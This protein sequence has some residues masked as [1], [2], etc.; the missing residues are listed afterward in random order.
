MPPPLALFLWLVLLLALLWFDPARVPKTSAALWV[1]LI[2]MFFLG[3]RA[4]TLWLSG[5]G[6]QVA[7]A[8]EE[9]TPLDHSIYLAL[10]LLAIGILVSR[11]LRW[12][13]FLTHN[14][15]LTAMLVFALV[16]VCWSD[17]SFIAFKRWFRDLGSY[18]VILVVLSDPQP[19]EAIRTLIRRLCYLLIPLSVVLVKY[20]PDIGRAYDFW[21]GTATYS[22][23]TT[24]KNMLGT[25]CLLSGLFFFWDTVT[26]WADRKERRTKRIILVNVGFIAM[27]IWL[28]YMCDS[29]TSRLCL[30]LG[31]LVIA[32]AHSKGSQRHPGFL[33]VM[34]PSAYLL[35]VVLAFGLGLNAQLAA[36]VGRDPT[37]TG[38][39]HI[40]DAVLSIHTD[41][42]L[43]VGYQSFWL[44]PRL[45]RVWS[46]YGGVINET[47]NGYLD[48]Y[49]NLGYIGVFLVIG[50][51]IAAYRNI[52]RRLKP[53]SILGSLTLAVWTILLFYNITE[54]AFEGGLL[55]MTLL[56]G[57]ISLPQHAMHRVPSVAAFEGTEA[58]EQLPVVS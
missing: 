46:T 30:I 32:A 9:G 57:A 7:G 3:S 50:F 6:G 22:G 20:F 51:L 17:Y 12:G 52:W 45:E 24:S 26:R 44:G 28:L 1:P 42:L 11:S 10:I 37:L 34:I 14:A 33:K 43:G 47:H 15:A 41:P 16:S 36:S 19:L 56:L 49:V 8:L 35:Y 23:A 38:R 39:T 48:V 18:L 5:K 29:A 31:C 13:A 40:W 25:A 55:W 53:F 58:S 4:P 21:T 54:A 27:T 2:W